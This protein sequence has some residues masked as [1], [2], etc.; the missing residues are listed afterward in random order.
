VVGEA[1]APRA[2]AAREALAEHQVV[3][4]QLRAPVEQVGQRARAVLGL[5]AV[6]LLDRHPWQLAALT[7]ELA[8][9]PV[10]LLLLL[11]QG[12][13]CGLPFLSRHDL[14]ARDGTGGHA[15]AA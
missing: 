5:E 10:E 2:G 3:D 13:V 11:A 4:E 14:H 12:V 8:L 6:L 7:V 1:R 15:A 9:A